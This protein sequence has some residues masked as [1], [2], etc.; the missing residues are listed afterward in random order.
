[1]LKP[2]AK[3]WHA[4]VVVTLREAY[5]ME[6]LAK[7][8]LPQ[9]TLTPVGIVPPMKKVVPPYSFPKLVTL[10]MRVKLWPQKL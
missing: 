6:V 8:N 9:I 1:M 10:V 2:H 7:L 4:L 3:F 5:A